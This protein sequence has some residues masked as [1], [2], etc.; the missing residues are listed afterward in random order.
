MQNTGLG[1]PECLKPAV[2]MVICQEWTV[3]AQLFDES[4]D[5]RRRRVISHRHELFA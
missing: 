2:R 5:T 1:F 3:T 4:G